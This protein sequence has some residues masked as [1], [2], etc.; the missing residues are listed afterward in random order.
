[1]CAD[2]REANKAVITD[3]FPLPHINEMLTSLRGTT[4]FSAIYL[5]TAY[6]QLPLHKDIRDVTAFITH[7]RLFRFCRVPY[8]LASVP[9]SF[10]KMMATI[11]KGVS[12][13]QNYLDNL[14]VYGKM[15][16]EHN[17]D[18]STV[19]QKLN[20]AGLVLDEKKKAISNRLHCVSWAM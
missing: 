1:M 10:Q 17:L 18:L 16:E 20:E 7:G 6:Y 9:S 5:A 12:G 11:L 3:C 14:I 13:V 4:I 19:L 8:G 15:A 2:L